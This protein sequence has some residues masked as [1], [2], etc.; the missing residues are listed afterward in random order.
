MPMNMGELAGL[1]KSAWPDAEIGDGPSFSTGTEPAMR[2]GQLRLSRALAGFMFHKF[3]VDLRE[4]T[5]AAGMRLADA[6]LRFGHEAVSRAVAA[7]EKARADAKTLKGEVRAEAGKLREME[8][9][10][11]RMAAL[12]AAAVREFGITING[13]TRGAVARAGRIAAS[14]VREWKKSDNADAAFEAIAEKTRPAVP[15]P[16]VKHQVRRATGQVGD[17]ITITVR[18]AMKRLYIAQ[19]RA[20]KAAEQMTRQEQT[21]LKRILAN[22]VAAALP[23][24][25]R[26]KFL[27]AIANVQSVAQLVKAMAKL[28]EALADFEKRQAIRS[29]R[30]SAAAVPGKMRPEYQSKVDAIREAIDLRKMTDETRR[31]LESLAEYLEKTPEDERGDLPASAIESVKR[32]AMRN[33]AD[34]TVEE[35]RGVEAALNSYVA[36]NELKN[37]LLSGQRKRRLE[38]VKGRAVGEI[39]RGVELSGQFQPLRAIGRRLGKTIDEKPDRTAL[40]KY[41]GELSA[42]PEQMLAEASETL[43]E[44]I[45]E[46]IGVR[47]H[48]REMALRQREQDKVFAA[49]RRAGMPFGRGATRDEGNAFSKWLGERLDVPAGGGA[50]RMTRGEAVYLYQLALDPDRREALL[51]RG[52]TLERENKKHVYMPKDADLRALPGVIGET[53][54]KLGEALRETYNGELRADLNREWVDVHYFEIATGTSY[55]PSRAD[56]SRMF[57][58]VED[59]HAARRTITIEGRGMFK[60]RDKGAT[61][62]LLVGDAMA[63]WAEHLDATAKSIAYLKPARDARLLLSDPGVRRAIIDRHGEPFLRFIE[64]LIIDQTLGMQKSRSAAGEAVSRLAERFLGTAARSILSVR[65]TTP[66]INFAGLSVS[67]TFLENPANMGRAMAVLGSPG[68]WARIKALAEQHAPYFR[69]RYDSFFKNVSAGVFGERETAWGVRPLTEYGLAGIEA[70]DKLAGYVRWRAIELDMAQKRPLLTPGS[71]EFYREVGLEWTRMMYRTES[72]S[73]PMDMNG[74]SLLG[75]KNAW[76]APFVMFQSA[77]SKVYSNMRRAAVEAGRGNWRRASVIAGGNLLSFA[78]IGALRM[79]WRELLRGDD[80]DEA[81]ER[82][83]AGNI[84]REIVSVLPVFG[85]TLA[86]VITKIETGRGFRTGTP[87]DNFAAALDKAFGAGVEAVKSLASDEANSE[88]GARWRDDALRMLDGMAGAASLATGLPYESG[89][90]YVELA[91]KAWEKISGREPEEVLEDLIKERGLDGADKDGKSITAQKNRAYRAI[92]EN[93][94]ERFESAV[95]G[96]LEAGGDA[97]TLG[98]ELARLVKSR[99]RE[100]GVLE[101]ALKKKGSIGELTVAQREALGAVMADLNRELETLGELYGSLPEDVWEKAGK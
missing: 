100:L 64:E 87:Y 80:E 93:D 49:M 50:V 48:N 1:V 28:Q 14:A 34:M 58:S 15:A 67:A 76:F 31:R 41:F 19:E 90:G 9:V 44:L 13:R 101:R 78:M 42:R 99:H 75:R 21:A 55:T 35:I 8:N 57:R 77:A 86:G 97:K 46:G 40:Q 92:L 73:H 18:E 98:Q 52:I 36:L 20:A 82:T 70:T 54:V 96:I 2:P 62:A 45:Y 30:K 71:D 56:P 85:E 60:D 84:V 10:N 22:E 94:A 59:L 65:P 61:A 66:L 37:T 69:E 91:G 39:G 4:A 53:G 16:A 83:L 25:E 43:R 12:T 72:T 26:G 79:A 74:L 32:L 29:L 5:E 88:G 17:T 24:A 38:E 81:T 89:K 68:E 51:N 3:M 63:V 7:R 95:R 27:K 33:V 23:P 6:H 11:G 47:G